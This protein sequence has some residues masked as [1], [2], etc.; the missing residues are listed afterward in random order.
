MADQEWL[1]KHFL[2]IQLNG[3]T[4]DAYIPRRAILAAVREMAH[5]FSGTLLDIGCGQMP[6]RQ[7]ILDANKSV[8]KYIGMDLESSSIHD[9]SVADLHWDAVTIPL[10]DAS[11][12]SAMATE[13]LEH[14]FEPEQTLGEI[15][16]VLKPGG[17]FFFT[18]PFIWPL[19]EVP[20]DAYRYTP[21]SLQRHL[22]RTGFTSIEIK[23]LGGWHA[24]FAQ[25]L[26]LWASE[27]NL[28]GYKKKL[29]I[30]AAKKL[31]PY[32]L[33]IDKRDNTFARH[34]MHTGLYGVAIKK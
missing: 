4:L 33:R 13:V 34:S 17:V 18:V 7:L 26:G 30:T 14:S 29:A 28:T 24:S 27:S 10:G 16:R 2:N 11:I 25:M 1:E 9:T 20:Y 22:E 5:V 32:L 12:D 21:F 15:N 8:S 19:H 23:S 6:Y 31:I 3:H